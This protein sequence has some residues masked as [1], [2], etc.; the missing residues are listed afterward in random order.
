MSDVNTTVEADDDE[1]DEEGYGGL[2][3]RTIAVAV[4]AGVA[5]GVVGYFVGHASAK[6]GPATLA[7]AVQQAQAGKLACGTPPA[8]AAGGGAG[9]AAGSGG[10]AGGGAGGSGGAG[11]AAAGGRGGFGG[12]NAAGFLVRA[13]CSPNGGA[14]ARP[15]GGFGG[16]AG[17]GAGGFRGGFGGVAG[18][19]ESVSGSSITI[20]GRDGQ[21]QTV[22]VDAST[23]VQKTTTG[24]VGDLKAGDDVT[25]Q[26]AGQDGSD[27]ATSIFVLPPGSSG[28]FGRGGFG[29]GG[30]APS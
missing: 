19:V 24:S 4:A 17:G 13:V 5:L 14:G 3:W 12:A 25:V 18:T 6:S 26:G 1:Y 16:A 10:A 9:G 20:K 11:G 22:K 8:S 15:G 27:T 21:T 28:R 2:P 29:A 7:D 30:G 23:R